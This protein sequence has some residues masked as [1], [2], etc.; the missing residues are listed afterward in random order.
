MS[1]QTRNLPQ[2]PVC[3]SPLAEADESCA[4]CGFELVE[5]AD[6]ID[7][8]DRTRHKEALGTARAAWLDLESALLDQLRQYG[9]AWSRNE[10]W[11]A[12][13]AHAQERAARARFDRRATLRRA[14]DIWRELERERSAAPP[15]VQSEEK[16]PEG[17]LSAHLERVRAWVSSLPDGEV[18]VMVWENFVES[19]EGPFDVFFLETFRDKEIERQFAAFETVQTDAVGN[20]VNRRRKRVR[21]LIERLGGGVELIMLE[22][23]G[24]E[25]QL[26]GDRYAWEQP[27]HR[28]RLTD[29]YLGRYPVTQAQ[30]REVAR[31]PRKNIDLSVDPSAFKGDD[32]PVECVSWPEALEFC[33]RLA[34]ETGHA[35]RL[36]SESEWEYACRAGSTTPF[37]FGPTIT[38]AVVNYDGAYPYGGAAHGPARGQTLAVGSLGAANAF[39]LCDLHGNVWEWCADE[40][41]DSYDAAPSDGAA[42]CGAGEARFR[43]VRGGSWVSTAEVC[44]SC[45]RWRESTDADVKLHYLGLRVALSL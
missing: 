19:L 30:W 7:I 4:R 44:R 17:T 26:G 23:P 20:L 41:H 18:D 36:P 28:V 43:V 3:R 1:N 45:D 14:R 9:E 24:G 33:A 32:R 10:N 13:W 27:A 39:G 29:F 25:F 6:L 5:S 37:S 16:K 31:L 42:W 11:Q 34:A 8:A 2:C 38:P 22:V 12:I 40:W 21:Q 15:P 35:Y